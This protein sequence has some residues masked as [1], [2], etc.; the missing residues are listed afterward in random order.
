[1][2]RRVDILEIKH[3]LLSERLVT[4]TGVP[5]VGKTRLALRVADEL[6]DEYPDGVW[7]LEAGSLGDGRLLAH[8]IATSLDLPSRSPR[9]PLA[10]LVEY[11]RDRKLLLIVDNCEHILDDCAEVFTTLLA[12]SA[13]VQVLATSRQA[14]GITGEQ[15][16]SVAPLASPG[17][18]ERRTSTDYPAITL[19]AERAFA[20]RPEFRVTAENWDT[21]AQIC[22]QLD[23]IPL[24]IELAAVRL[25]TNSPEQ[26][27]LGLRD[28]CRMLST[29]A[30][31][32]LERHRSL[33]AAID[34]S[35]DLCSAAEQTLWQRL[36]VFPESFDLDT[37]EEVCNGD[38]IPVDEVLELVTGLLD[39]SIL[40][41][42]QRA[43]RCRYRMLGT[44]R[45]YGWDKLAPTERAGLQRRHRDRYLRLVEQHAATWFGPDQVASC[46]RLR[47]DHSDIRAALEFSLSTHGETRTGLWLA[48]TL[49]FFWVGCGLLSE[50]RYWLSQAL[51]VN[52]ELS[53]ERVKALW[54]DAWIAR[55]QGDRASAVSLAQQCRRG[56]VR[57]GDDVAL[58]HAVHVLGTT[59]F[60]SDDM[61][62]A[63]PLLAE[64]RQRLATVLARHSDDSE[65]RSALALSGVQLAVALAFQG[66]LDQATPLC[67]ECLAQCGKHSERW[68]LSYALLGLALTEWFMRRRSE[69]AE[70]ARECLRIEGGFCDL[71]GM[72][73]S[74]DVLAWLAAADG[75]F[76]RATVLL[77]GTDRMWEAFGHRLFGSKKWTAP[78][79]ECED[80]CRRALGPRMFEATLRRGHNLPTGE[81]VAY[82][83]A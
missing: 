27:L 6:R 42:E 62:G 10:D 56:A 67:E 77:G 48:A 76:E 7:F 31:T 4:L 52:R 80:Q 82:A 23:G 55:V 1:V 41:R 37:A 40:V 17:E 46:H 61:Q 14:L 33:V 19:F 8:M 3:R 68:V 2:G 18:S 38:A 65:L 57:L 9:G 78:R 58:A 43:E 25:S 63:V 16:W 53:R 74:V 24:A 73:L 39:K 11:L 83:L 49:W 50:G 44:L 79:R 59:A 32:A 5:G 69:A 30:G 15:I 28:R 12:A 29:T 13:D 47:Q 66:H 64:A 22:R 35:F 26:L 45:Q 51:R 34:W 20:V 21:I 71:L 72:A 54:V 36:A 60:V 70:H 81:I 75:S